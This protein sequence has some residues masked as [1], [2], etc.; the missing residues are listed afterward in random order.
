MTASLD[1][2]GHDG[3]LKRVCGGHYGLVPHIERLDQN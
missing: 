2:L 3:L 1:R